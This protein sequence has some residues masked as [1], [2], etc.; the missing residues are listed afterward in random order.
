MVSWEKPPARHDVTVPTREGI[1]KELDANPGQ[2]AL[3]AR[4]DR[5]VR[6]EGQVAR[7]ESGREFGAGFQ[8]V[9]RQ[10]GNEHRV[11]ARKVN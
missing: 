2:W 4:H 7:I 8:A 3:V 11:Y 9:Y 6:A 1:G 10:V 5:A